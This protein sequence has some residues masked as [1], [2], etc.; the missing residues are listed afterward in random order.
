MVV[1]NFLSIGIISSKELT[2]GN[3]AFT[4]YPVHVYKTRVFVTHVPIY[5]FTI[6][7]HNIVSGKFV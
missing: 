5:R 3:Y 6:S 4:P 1:F 2:E 7:L